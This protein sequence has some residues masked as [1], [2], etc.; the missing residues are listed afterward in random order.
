MWF[1]LQYRWLTYSIL[2]VSVMYVYIFSVLA[3]FFPGVSLVTAVTLELLR[4][5]L[6]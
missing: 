4:S 6:W 3:I 5:A 1:V 2:L